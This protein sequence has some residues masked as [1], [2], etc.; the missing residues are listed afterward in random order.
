[1][2][3]SVALLHPENDYR[4]MPASV[5]SEQALIGALLLNNDVLRRVATV[6]SEEAF[7][8]PLHRRIWHVACGLIDKGQ[9]AGVI[10]IKTFLGSDAVAAGV[11]IPQYLARLAAEAAPPSQA[12]D[13]AKMVRDLW[14]RRRIITAAQGVMERAYDAPVEDTPASILSA[15]ETGIEELRPKVDQESSDFE[16][17][18]AAAMRAVGTAMDAYQRGGRLVGLPTGMSRLDEAL[19]GL[20]GSDLV[21]VAGR[22]GMGKTALATNIAY[23][24]AQMLKTDGQKGVVAFNS[25]EMS[26]EQLSQ[27]IIS[28]KSGV[29]N[30]KIRRGKAS[31]A[32]LERYDE[33]AREL[34]G[35]PLRIDQ[36][37][38]LTVNSLRLRVRALHKRAGIRLLVIDY[39]QLLAGTG[40]KGGDFNRNNEVTEITGG[41]KA[42]AKELNIPIIA[43]SQLSRRV[44][45]RDDKRPMLSDLR[46][47]GSIEQDADVVMFVFREEYYLKKH[48]PKENTEAHAKWKHAM[49]QAEGVAQVIIA[50]QRHGPEGTVELGFDASLTR[51][52][53]EPEARAPEPELPE[54]RA[55]AAA[56]TPAP[57]GDALTVYGI[58]RALT[59]SHHARAPTKE[60]LE[61]DKNLRSRKAP[62]VIPMDAVKEKLAEEY[63]HLEQPELEKL[64]RAA[65]KSLRAAEM[66]LYIVNKEAPHVWCPKLVD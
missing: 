26:A 66:V 31:S 33:T 13:H 38:G 9:N 11:T 55:R 57:T 58:L 15:F 3:A 39:L 14:V 65:F 12:L 32:E 50:K 56:T 6:V 64:W 4:E 49:W 45:E 16:T 41:L 35:L 47:S 60:E 40:R 34:R 48:E 7:F 17:F 23:A 53:D 62:R 5:E 30:W 2:S 27:R 52:T 42:L 8:E 18:D 10:S 28:E 63:R 25:L 22:P 54:R 19:G 24:V 21:I 20:H 37:G 43:L 46:E 51:F 29:P 36:T 59:L 61:A 44:E 1:M